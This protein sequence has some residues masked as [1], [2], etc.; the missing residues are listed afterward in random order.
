MPKALIA[1]YM[2]L[3]VAAG[4][5]LFGMGWTRGRKVAAAVALVAPFPMLFLL[6]PERPFA[7]LQRGIGLSL[8][9][10][11]A[12]SLLGGMAVAWMRARR[13]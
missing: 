7:D 8:I 3:T 11:G 12:L 6:H 9:A 5:R 13:A 1:F 4:W 2:L 10:G